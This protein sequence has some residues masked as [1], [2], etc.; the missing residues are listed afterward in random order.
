M[1]VKYQKMDWQMDMVF[2]DTQKMAGTVDN[3]EMEKQ[4]VLVYERLKVRSNSIPLNLKNIYY[5]L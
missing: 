5:P 3:F 2:G 1:K 4:M